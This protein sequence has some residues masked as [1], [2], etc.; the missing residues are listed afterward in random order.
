MGVANSGSVGR[1][2]TFEVCNQTAE[3]MLRIDSSRHSQVTI[4]IPAGD[5]KP[6]GKVVNA[7]CVSQKEAALLGSRI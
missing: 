2:K 1:G 7:S 5:S 6:R 3:V 4:M